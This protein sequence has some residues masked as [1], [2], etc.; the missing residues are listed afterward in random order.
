MVVMRIVW[1]YVMRRG[2]DE[3]METKRC[4]KCGEEKP[5]DHF[6][7]R[8]ASPDGLSYWCRQC[9]TD[10]TRKWR[11]NN[12]DRFRDLNS[13]ASAK[14]RHKRYYL[15]HREEILAKNRPADKLV[16]IESI[17]RYP[18]EACYLAKARKLMRGEVVDPHC[19]TGEE[20]K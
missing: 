6:Q 7:K 17:E 19:D 5:I 18:G 16:P 12:P 14:E 2:G 1:I 11:Q 20:E 13:N 9:N 3:E 15:R 4:S 8:K 10:Y